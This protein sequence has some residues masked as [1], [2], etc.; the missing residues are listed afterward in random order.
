MRESVTQ[1]RHIIQT[2][3]FQKVIYVDIIYI[4]L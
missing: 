1:L 4:L 3:L 2:E